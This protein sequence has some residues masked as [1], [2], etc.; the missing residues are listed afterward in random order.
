MKLYILHGWTYNLKPW[1]ETIKRLRQAGVTVVMLRLPGLTTPSSRV[2]QV[3]DYL[4]WLAKELKDPHPILLGHSNGGRLGLHYCQA[5]PDHLKKLI[6]LNS[7]GVLPT[8]WQLVRRRVLRSLSALGQPLK[9]IPG[10]RRFVYRYLVGST[11]YLDARPNMK[12]TLNNLL[13]ADSQISFESIATPINIIWGQLDQAT[14]LWQAQVLRT[15]LPHVLSYDVIAG[16][17][18]AP[19]ATH[20]NQLADLIL[21]NLGVKK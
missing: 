17:R 14:P 15:K 10:V 2:W 1:Q 20:P 7:A 9:K 12:K 4:D 6:L 18:H 13:Q 11:D 8:K 3:A 5:N 21:K 16:A 19:Y